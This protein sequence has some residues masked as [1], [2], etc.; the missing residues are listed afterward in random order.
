M[1]LSLILLAPLA[2]CSTAASGTADDPDAGFDDSV[3]EDGGTDDTDG[4]PTTPVGPDLSCLT[5]PQP[6]PP[7]TAVNPMVLAGQVVELTTVGTTHVDAADVA[8][9]RAG[10]PV[11]LARTTSASNGAFATGALNTNGRAVHAY[12]KAMKKGYRTTFAYPPVPY[13]TSS[14]TLVVPMMSD[15]VFSTVKTSLGAQQNDAHNGALLV[16]V[17]DCNDQPIAGATLSV[18][19]GMS[20]VGNI[21]ELGTVLPAD[22]GVFVVFNVPDGKVRVS[23]S[24][25]GTPLPEHEV[26]VRGTDPDCAPPYGTL[27]HTIVK[28]R[29]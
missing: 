1:R 16:A 14:T 18:R 3:A 19:R 12:L 20:S 5:Q 28:P 26:V 27:T 17:L 23:A 7:T 10:T 4:D 9:F 29:T 6:P 21:R 22:D 11:V 25:Q 8:L 24:Y 15:A 13:S 2:A